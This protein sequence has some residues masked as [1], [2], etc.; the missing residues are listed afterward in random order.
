MR[1]SI[2]G[3]DKAYAAVSRYLDDMPNKLKRVIQLLVDSGVDIARE[4]VIDLGAT[5]TYELEGS[6]QGLVYAEG[7]KGI[8]FS[9]CPYAVYVEVGTGV[10]GKGE[11]HPTHPWAYDV[12]SHGQAG[13][14][15]FTK[16][17]SDPNPTKKPSK[18]GD[19]YV[20]WTRGMPS[21]PF[22]QM[23]SVALRDKLE[24]IVKEAFK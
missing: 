12:N 14:W 16:D 5:W 6:I 19:G 2:T 18:Q 4:N 9:D 23:T 15:Y 17:A 8:I 22:M 7:N 21:R 24:E 10:V 3:T 13:W 1:I 20:A 11:P